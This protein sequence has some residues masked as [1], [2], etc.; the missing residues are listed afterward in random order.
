MDVKA[1]LVPASAD[2]VIGVMDQK[3]ETDALG[4]SMLRGTLMNESGQVVNVP[5]VIAT[6]YDNSGH[7]IWVSDGYVDRALYPQTPEPFA[8]EIPRTVADKVENY[9]VV[10]NQ[11]SISKQ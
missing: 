4:R 5:H 3:R 11:Y 2:P 8:V 10:V 6:F 7:V 1:T 9:H